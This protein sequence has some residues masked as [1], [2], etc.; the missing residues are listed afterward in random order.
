MP[1]E[2]F[3]KLSEEKKARITRAALKEFL[4]VPLEEVSINRII[5]DAEISRGSFYTYFEDKSDVLAYVFYKKKE[6]AWLSIIETL[7]REQGD[8]W[9]ASLRWYELALQ[10]LE[11]S[12]FKDQLRSVVRV[13]VSY[14]TE[15]M[16]DCRMDESML[17]RIE[18]LIAPPGIPETVGRDRLR[19][20]LEMLH[21]ALASA[22]FQAA[23]Y[24]ER[25]AQARKLLE[26]KL[27]ILQAGM[28]RG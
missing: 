14:L 26:E 13:S 27:S 28:Q 11:S 18:Q 4:R 22:V 15:A 20:C 8:L 7:E 3:L 6:A 2:R 1:S 21:M 9:R 23:L 17:E 10:R 19:A 24:P 12:E 5:Q 16:R 25:R